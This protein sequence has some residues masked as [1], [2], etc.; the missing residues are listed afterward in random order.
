MPK[1]IYIVTL[2]CAKNRVDTEVMLGILTKKG[3]EIVLNPEEADI[4]IVNS[5][6]FISDAREESIETVME[7]SAIKKKEKEKSLVLAGCLSQRYAKVLKIFF[8]EVDKFIG[9]GQV[10]RIA[11]ILESDKKFFIGNP[12]R[13]LYDHTMPRILT[14]GYYMAYVKV[15]E[16]CFRKCTFCIIPKLRGRFRSRSID[17]VYEEVKGLASTGIKEINLIAQDLTSYGRDLNDGTSLYHLLKRLVL[18]KGIEW[19]RMLYLYPE[20]SLF[21]P[22]LLSLIANEEKIVKYIDIPVQHISSRILKMMGRNYSREEVY[23]LIHLLRDKVPGVVL[24]STVMVGFPGETEEE[25]N[26]LLD[27]ISD[28]RFD[29]L[30]AFSFSNEL[31][32]KASHL[33]PQ[34]T[35]TIK[36]KR[37]RKL[38]HI[39]KRITREKNLSLVGKTVDA[40]IEFINEDKDFIARHKG[41][42]PEVDGV[43]LINGDT[44]PRF[45]PTKVKIKKAYY[46]Y[47]LI[48]EIVK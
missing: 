12:S 11:E 27:F 47:D 19:I 23:D 46:Y 4:I 38:M 41:Q 30:G 42:A 25:Y 32:T 13:F 36:D 18:V 39:Q 15:A 16:G 3:Y 48:G 7:L 26:E 28:I 45:N 44:Q 29:W 43:L 6:A 17:S 24:R 14:T 8:P 31:G 40:L 20:P 2:G 22:E 34:F 10:D 35:K 33:K 21:T 9:P 37:K 5:C 1:N